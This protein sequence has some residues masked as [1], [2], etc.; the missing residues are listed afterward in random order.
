[1]SPGLAPL[2]DL[3]ISSCGILNLSGLWF[4]EVLE[5]RNF[6][7]FQAQG[8]GFM[9]ISV[10]RCWGSE[11]ARE[12]RWWCLGLWLAPGAPWVLLMHSQN[13]EPC[14]YWVPMASAALTP[15]ALR[16]TPFC[17]WLAPFLLSFRKEKLN[18]Y[19]A[20]LTS[21][22]SNSHEEEKAQTHSL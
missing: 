17:S 19:F 5:F 8:L 13:T 18:L 22:I 11:R 12:F 3:R 14:P 9:T 4:L 6:D 21:F 20:I 15:F 1:M 2:G 7:L 16:S 10:L